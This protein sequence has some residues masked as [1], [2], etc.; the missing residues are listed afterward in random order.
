[1]KEDHRCRIKFL[2]LITT[3]GSSRTEKI[4]LESIIQSINKSLIL[5]NHSHGY[6]SSNLSATNLSICPWNLFKQVLRR[7]RVVPVINGD[8]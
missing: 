2:T 6:P 5:L 8:K 7:E 1:M 4:L 3:I